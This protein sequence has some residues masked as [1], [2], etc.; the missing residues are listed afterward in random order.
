MDLSVKPN[1]NPDWPYISEYLL[2]HQVSAEVH[3]LCEYAYAH[4]W[5][6]EGN[7]AS[8]PW[9]DTW[10]EFFFPSELDLE[11]NVSSYLTNPKDNTKPAKLQHPAFVFHDG[12][13][14]RRGVFVLDNGRVETWS[15]WKSDCFMYRIMKECRFPAKAVA[16]FVGVNAGRLWIRW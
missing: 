9:R 1:Y 12:L 6:M 11:D 4:L 2:R 7:G 5:D 15:R 10:F 13:W 14:R 8:V 16:R 3:D